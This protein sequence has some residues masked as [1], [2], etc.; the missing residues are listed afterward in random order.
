MVT[1]VATLC[2]CAGCSARVESAAS[3][4]AFSRWFTYQPS[5]KPS[6]NRFTTSTSR[7]ARPLTTAEP[8]T[9]CCGATRREISRPRSS[10]RA[11]LRAAARRPD[12]SKPTCRRSN[13]KPA[14]GVRFPRRLRLPQPQ[15]RR[16]TRGL[17]PPGRASRLGRPARQ[18]H[19]GPPRRLRLA[20]RVQHARRRQ[21][22][23]P[24]TH[25]RLRL[26][27]RLFRSIRRL[28][29]RLYR[30]QGGAAR[31]TQDREG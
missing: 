29:I 13:V 18:R 12:A 6:I 22:P 10:L 16:H 28:H 21:R 15:P 31:H 27:T 8:Y 3:P 17:P 23:G 9:A 30:A 11:N 26:E 7:A 25:L 2:E 20:Q 4:S 14:L 19:G 5:P 1:T 24:P